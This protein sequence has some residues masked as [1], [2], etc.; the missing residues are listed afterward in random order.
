VAGLH[1]RPR[2]GGQAHNPAYVLFTAPL[3]ASTW[4]GRTLRTLLG[5]L[6]CADKKTV[7]PGAR[8]NNRG[9]LVVASKAVMGPWIAGAVR[10]DWI[11]G[12]QEAGTQRVLRRNLKGGGEM[13]GLDRGRGGHG[14]D[15]D[16]LFFPGP[17]WGQGTMPGRRCGGRGHREGRGRNTNGPN[18]NR[19]PGFGAVLGRT[20]KKRGFGGWGR[21]TGPLPLRGPAGGNPVGL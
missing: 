4:A 3:S 5:G 12:H 20:E 17:S 21:Q 7:L 1:P 6:C 8:R 11:G 18:Q 14:A 9:T 15:V 10:S 19:G 2:S 13:F 16:R